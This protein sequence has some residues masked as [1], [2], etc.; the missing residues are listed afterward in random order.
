PT[1]VLDLGDAD[2]TDVKIAAGKGIIAKYV[3]LSYCWG[4]RAG[5]LPKITKETLPVWTT[6]IPSN[7]LPVL[8][9][10]IISITRALGLRYL[11][12]DSLCILQDDVHDWERESGHMAA[13]YEGSWLTIAATFAPSPR[14]TLFDPRLAHVR[15]RNIR[16]VKPSLIPRWDVPLMTR[17]WAFQERLLSPRI[18]HFHA[19][20]LV[21]ECRAGLHKPNATIDDIGYVW[22]DLVSEFSRLDLTKDSDRLPALS[23]IASTMSD[24]VMGPYVAGLWRND[25]A[26]CLM[27][28]RTRENIAVTKGV[29]FLE[30]QCGP[31]RPSWSWASL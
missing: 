9:Q 27:F 17:A 4:R 30:K 20:E 13:V 28:E 18:L 12:I 3:A 21:W 7:I 25:V 11:W 19:E 8:F 31:S 5:D 24:G 26:R 1:R 2:T 16:G 29:N 14:Q 23:G 22:L 10:E 6:Q 15:F